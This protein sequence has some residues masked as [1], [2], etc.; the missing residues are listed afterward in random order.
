MAGAIVKQKQGLGLQLCG[1]TL[2]AM[3]EA[4]SSIPSSENESAAAEGAMRTKQ[5]CGRGTDGS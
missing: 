5:T 2:A 4:P 1:R 3:S